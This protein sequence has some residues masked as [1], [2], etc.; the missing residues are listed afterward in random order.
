MWRGKVITVTCRE[1]GCQAS[2]EQSYRAANAWWVAKLAELEAASVPPHPFPDAIANLKLRLDWA[3]SEADPTE[4]SRISARLA[5]V[6]SMDERHDDPGLADGDLI[7]ANI[8]TAE[9]GGVVVPT[10]LDP[11]FAHE[12][13]GDAD[14][15]RERRRREGST[16]TPAADTLGGHMQRYLDLARAR[17]RAGDLSASEVD[18]TRLCLA[19]FIAYIGPGNVPDSITSA[20]WE[21]YWLQLLGEMGNGISAEYCRKRF[22]HAKSF[23]S[24]LTENGAG[25]APPNFGSRR[26]RFAGPARAIRVFSAAEARALVD[27]APGQLRLHLLLMIN[28]GF[29]QVDISGLQ[30]GEVGWES[31][32]IT[33]RRSKTRHHAHTPTVG[34][35]LWAETFALLRRHRA[36]TGDRVLTTAS[37]AHWV[38]TSLRPDG[39]LSKSDSINSNYRHL[40]PKHPL[41]VF[42]ATSATLLDSSVEFRG[43]SEHFLG[44]AGRTVAAKHYLS[45][46][47][48]GFASQFDRAVRWL[49]EQYGFNTPN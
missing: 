44:H 16:T 31:G 22:R 48:P 14:L 38:R 34:Y 28:C 37:G 8:R 24:W 6:E 12:L 11:M 47:T 15:W 42:R 39:K 2:K 9:L 26:H 46:D 33:R 35:P 29:T 19:H 18:L 27:R 21:G 40:A 30:D 17:H 1:L 45:R 41:K 20:R 25:V 49:G 4:V 13:F 3:V 36:E 43:F 5:E 32:R 23:I 10:D 7:R